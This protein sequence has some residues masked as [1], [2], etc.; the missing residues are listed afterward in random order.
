MIQ[1]ITVSDLQGKI[2]LEFSNVQSANFA[3]DI[4]GLEKGFYFIN[5]TDNY[6]YSYFQKFVKTV[7]YES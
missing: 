1:H 5:A 7:S 2:L 4:S 3:M 6:E